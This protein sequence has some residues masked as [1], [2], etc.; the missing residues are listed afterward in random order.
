MSRDG[1]AIP[2]QVH[3]KCFVGHEPGDCSL[4]R[5]APSLD[6]HPSIPPSLLRSAGMWSNLSFRVHQRVLWPNSLASICVHHS[7]VRPVLSAYSGCAAR[8]LS[9][10]LTG[11]RDHFCIPSA[12]TDL[13]AGAGRN[14]AQ[15]QTRDSTASTPQLS[16]VSYVHINGQPLRW[17]SMNMTL[18]LT[19]TLPL[20]IGDCGRQSPQLLICI[21]Q[22][23][24]TS[25]R[26]LLRTPA[27]FTVMNEPS[28]V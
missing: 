7:P 5:S 2:V 9:P 3:T 17:P 21:L 27:S 28:E 8:P 14:C 25:K 19:L 18:T 11:R 4:A 16:P 26:T 23:E 12:P 22:T 6:H 1:P 15:W 24:S 13:E 20:V 10:S